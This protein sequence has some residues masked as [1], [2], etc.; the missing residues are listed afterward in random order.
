MIVAGSIAGAAVARRPGEDEA[1][2]AVPKP[3]RGGQG[4]ALAGG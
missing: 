1:G 3:W 4:M 2:E